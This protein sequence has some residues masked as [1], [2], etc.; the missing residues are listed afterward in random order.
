MS[1]AQAIADRLKAVAMEIENKLSE[2][3]DLLASLSAHGCEARMQIVQRKPH[4][5]DTRDI[6]LYIR[7]GPGYYAIDLS[8][9]KTITESLA[10]L[11]A[12]PWGK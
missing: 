12:D 7:S 8:V 5:H 6:G 11:T 4:S 9:T 2:A 3:Q 10:Q 1:G